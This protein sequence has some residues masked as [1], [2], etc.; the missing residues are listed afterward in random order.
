[1]KKKI[2]KEK[3]SQSVCMA[4][5][6]EVNVCVCDDDDMVSCMG[7]SVVMNGGADGSKGAQEINDQ[8]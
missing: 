2:I 7:H 5:V 1:M 4:I 6:T 8:C 3:I